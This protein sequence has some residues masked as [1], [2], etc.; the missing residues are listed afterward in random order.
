MEGYKWAELSKILKGR[1]ENSIKNRYF[2][3]MHLHGESRKK[4]KISW[5]DEKTLIDALIKKIQT[6]SINLVDAQNHI[7][8][9]AGV[10][11]FEDYF[12]KNS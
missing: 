10:C 3:L 4:E 12:L 7:I 11:M 8:F 9:L 1:N 2:T 6:S 5:D